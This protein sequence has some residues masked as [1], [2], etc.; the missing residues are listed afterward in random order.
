M[1][2]R[3]SS[4]NEKS[5]PYKKPVQHQHGNRLKIGAAEKAI[6]SVPR[7]FLVTEC[8]G[9]NGWIAQA[10]SPQEAIV[11][12]HQDIL[13]RSSPPQHQPQTNDDLRCNWDQYLQLEAKPSMRNPCFMQQCQI[14]HKTY[15]VELL[16]PSSKRVAWLPASFS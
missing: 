5:H 3:Q 8:G 7:L 11:F 12:F 4:R 6:E 1:N 13:R 10:E 9:T 15:Y 14:G 16:A 2:T